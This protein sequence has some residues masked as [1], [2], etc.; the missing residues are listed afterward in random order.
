MG[1]TDV[2]REISSHPASP[3]ERDENNPI[4]AVPPGSP[5]DNISLSEFDT[6]VMSLYVKCWPCNY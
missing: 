1:V 3:S 5:W 2:L 6:I 4:A